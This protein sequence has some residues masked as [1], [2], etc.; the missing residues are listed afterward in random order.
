MSIPELNRRARP[1]QARSQAT[2]ERVLLV[3]AELLE[4]VGVNGFNTNLL[5]RRV[6]VGVRAIYRYFP[7]KWA[8]LVALAEGFGEL[9]RTWVGDLKHPSGADLQA[10]IDR[11]I[12]GYYEGAKRRPGY[13]ALRAAAQASPEL[14]LVDERSNRALQEDLAAGL[15]DFGVKL[16]DRQLRT[17]CLVI[18]ETANRLLDLALQAEPEEAARIVTELKRMLLAF[19]QLYVTE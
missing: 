19:L 4:E 3:S 12:D 9:E 5:A 7:N 17:L 8:I 18:I 6:G 10:S 14:R 11:A 1:Q 15:R 16:D 13:A 2:V